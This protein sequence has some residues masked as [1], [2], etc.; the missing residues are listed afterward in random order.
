[1]P[2]TRSKKRIRGGSSRSRP[3]VPNDNPSLKVPRQT[4]WN[5]VSCL[6]MHRPCSP[7][8]RRTG[9]TRR[10]RRPHPKQYG[11]NRPSNTTGRIIPFASRTLTFE[12]GVFR[13]HARDRRALCI[14]HAH[15]FHLRF[16]QERRA[17]LRGCIQ[18]REFVSSS[19][20]GM[21]TPKSSCSSANSSNAMYVPSYESSGCCLRLEA[22][23]SSFASRNRFNNV[24]M[25]SRS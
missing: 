15:R 23:K 3:S 1:M 20:I 10:G 24:A 7:K 21:L 19:Y 12:C 4:L 9:R 13:P 17:T 22:T 2:H 5:S 25:F 6:T 14:Q 11:R 18:H 8:L 16:C